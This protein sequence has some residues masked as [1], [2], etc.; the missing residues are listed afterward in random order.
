[1]MAPDKPDVG[2]AEERE[3]LSQAGT[4]PLVSKYGS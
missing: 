2:E 3:A 4:L 1:M